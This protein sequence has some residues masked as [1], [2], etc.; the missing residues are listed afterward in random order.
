MIDDTEYLLVG[1]YNCNTEQEQLKT[2]QNLSVMLENIDSFCSNNEIIAS[3]YNLFFSKKLEC[4][5]GDPYL[6]KHPVSHIIKILETSTFIHFQIKSF[7]WC[8]IQ[9]S[10]L[11]ERMSNVDILNAF[12]CNPVFCSFMKSFK[13]SQGSGVWKFNNS[14]ISNNDFLEE[15]KFFI[16]NTKLFLEQIFFPNQ[17][18]CEFSKYE[19]CKKCVSFSKVLA[20]KSR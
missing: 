1:V 5:D 19:I 9:C 16:Y 2:L 13:Y 12:K 11:Q 8:Y 10:I 20:Q 18:K 3:D 6:K 14:L 4:Q 15:M 7:F 17:S